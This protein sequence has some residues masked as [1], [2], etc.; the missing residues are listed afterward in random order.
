MIVQ[1]KRAF[2]PDLQSSCSLQS[3]L[4]YEC[5]LTILPGVGYK[6]TKTNESNNC[7]V[8]EICVIIINE[9]MIITKNIRIRSILIIIT[10]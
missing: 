6:L 2:L 9:E 4:S 10:T 5:K 7:T 8:Y 3:S 1:P